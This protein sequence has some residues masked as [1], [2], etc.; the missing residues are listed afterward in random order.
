MK[1][2]WILFDLGGVLVDWTGPQ[3]LRAL[4]PGM[5]EDEY[6][7][8]WHA[9]CATD[10]FERGDLAPLEFARQ[11]AA[12]WGLALAPD[13]MLARYID[14]LRGFYPGAQAL[15]AELR[16]GAR[17]ACLSNSNAAHWQSPVG[18]AL[19]AEFDIPLAS[20]ELRLRK[21]QPE[22]FAL[23]LQRLGAAAHEVLYFDDL[24]PN[25]EAARAAGMNAQ[26]VVGLPA[27]RRQ[28]A[29]LGL[30]DG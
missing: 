25:V 28:L 14:W 9:C 29:S 5:P 16:R 24:L 18:R 6:A 17:L 8:R 12:N 4:L 3:Q 15:L 11:F 2:T 22:I 30:I 20:H 21:P 19:V 1:P 26:H 7:Q 10:R 27:L 23:A 13:D